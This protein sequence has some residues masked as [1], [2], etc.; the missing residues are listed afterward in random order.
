MSLYLMM[1]Q[2]TVARVFSA[3]KIKIDFETL[4]Q[5]RVAAV[6]SAEKCP[7]HPQP[8]SRVGARGADTRDYDSATF[9][10]EPPPEA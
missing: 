10:W 2:N 7:P 8:L 6:E 1:L 5:S 3:S 4:I 9:E